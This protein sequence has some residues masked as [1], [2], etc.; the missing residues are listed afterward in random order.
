M[1]ILD[2][3]AA[4]DTAQIVAELM[5]SELG[6]DKTWIDAELADFHKVASKY[7]IT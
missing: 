2:A 3:Q 6:K 5:A 7:L 1:L 4:I